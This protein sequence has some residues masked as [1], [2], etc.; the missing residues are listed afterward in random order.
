MFDLASNFTLIRNDRAWTDNNMNQPKTGGGIAIYINSDLDFSENSH[1]KYNRST[2]DIECQWISISQP[3]SKLTVVGNIYRPPQGNIDVFIHELDDILSQIDID[4]IELFLMGDFNI[5]FIEKGNQATSKLIDCIKPFGLR[6]LIKEPTRYSRAKNSCLDLFITNSNDIDRVGVCDI[7]LSDHQ[8]IMLTRKKVQQIKK[9]SEFVG[10][11]YRNYN[12]DDFQNS[13]INENWENFENSNTVDGKWEQIERIIRKTIDEMCTCPLKTFKIKQVK[14]P[15]ISNRLIEL[16]KDKDSALKRAKKKKDPQL[17]N[18]AKHQRNNCIKRLRTARAD[19][20]KENLDNDIG[21]QK[22]FWKNIQKVFLN[23]KGSKN[24]T[25]FKLKDKNNNNVIKEENAATFINDFFINIGPNLAKKC[26]NV[27]NFDGIPCQNKIEN[28]TTDAEEISKLCDGININKSSSIP[29]LSSEILRDAFK[30]IPDKIAIL[31]NLSFG[32]A[33]IPTSWK[34]AKVT[35]LQKPGK[36]D[37][38]SNLR[39]VSHLPLPSKL[40]EKIVHN[41]IYSHCENNNI[42]DDRQ[43]GFRPNHSTCHTTA[44][45]I[46]DIYTAMNTNE[47]LLAVYIDAMKAFDTVNHN[48]LLQKAKHYGIDG[49]LLAWLENYLSERY[50]CTVANDMCSDLKL[51]TCGVPQGSVCGPLLFL[52][53]INDVSCVM[54][55]CKVSLYADDTVLYTSNENLDLS[56]INLQE[57][58]DNL[59]AWCNRNKLTINSKKTKYCVYGLR[60]AIKKSKTKDISLSLNAD[61]LDRVCSYKY[62]GFILDDH[63]TFNKHLSELFKHLSHKLYLLSKIRKYLTREASIMVFK[64]MI[65][66][67]IEYGDT[68]YAGTNYENLRKLDR[69]FYRG[70]RI[71][72][73]NHIALDEQDLCTECNIASLENRRKSHLLIFMHKQKEI[74]SMLS[75][76]A[77][78]TRLHT[79]PVF[80]CYKPNNEKVRKNVIYRGAIN[81]NAQSANVR[82]LDIREF[83]LLQ[84]R[85]LVLSHT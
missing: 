47:T 82:N 73:G 64:T 62:L 41:R 42:L 35:P 5:D 2:K 53:Y 55:N 60:S 48:I 83:K 6:Q 40:I 17:W 27:W 37:D 1:S 50:Q 36:R 32:N 39:P 10:R 71:C 51:I 68:L 56:V 20:I 78:M 65:L 22:K 8:M 12:R 76:P 54:K 4:K 80:W 61:I 46:N 38:V 30:I 33:D 16:I 69:F 44:M 19:F 25:I 24:N 84:K 3:H 18:E 72:I 14:E 28:I 23:K 43:G 52:L 81:W 29:H 11:S 15:W 7:N 9:K 77:R 74:D 59:T 66:S 85:E 45:F 57:D 79:A 70:L 67:I 49:N 31:F 13:I 26:S 58:L 34:T 63:L 21:N 75:K